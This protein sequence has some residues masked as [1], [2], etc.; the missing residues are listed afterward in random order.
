VRHDVAEI[1]RRVKAVRRFVRINAKTPK[2]TSDEPSLMD[3]RPALWSCVTTP[4]QLRTILL[5]IP[6][7][8]DT[9]GLLTREDLQP[10][11]EIP[12]SQAVQSCFRGLRKTIRLLLKHARNV[13]RAKY[14]TNLLK[15]VC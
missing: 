4:L 10:N 14:G 11:G 12:P 9:L 13:R 8:L 5:L 3:N 6:R 15:N 1:R 7:G 2:T